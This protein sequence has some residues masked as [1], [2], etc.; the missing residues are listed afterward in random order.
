MNKIYIIGRLTRAAEMN[1]T[2]QGVAFCR[3]TLASRGKQ[4][5][6][7]GNYK[8]EFFNCIAWRGIAEVISKYTT[9]GTSVC[10]IGEMAART[11]DKNGE[12]KTVWEV[13]VTDVELLGDEK[14]KDEKGNAKG[15]KAADSDF[16]DEE[17]DGELPF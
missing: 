1:E 4:R 6:E 3:F 7:D 10:V 14:P 5:G 12:S 17:F 11:Y 15:K 13:N 9:K 2:K 16:N 8:P